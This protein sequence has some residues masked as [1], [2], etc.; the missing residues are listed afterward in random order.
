MLRWLPHLLLGNAE[1]GHEKK[2]GEEE[3]EEEKEKE[4]VEDGV[5]EGEEGEEEEEKKQ[6]E[7]QEPEETGVC[8]LSQVRFWEVGVLKVAQT[9]SRCLGFRRPHRRFALVSAGEDTESEE[10]G[11]QR[12]AGEAQRNGAR[13]LGVETPS[14]GPA[15]HA[16]PASPGSSGNA[17]PLQG[18][19]T[20]PWGETVWPVWPSITRGSPWIP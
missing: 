11:E 6:E 13:A 20:R 3:E 19:V 1:P 5:E 18:H 12:G 14:P 10:A 9:D 4:E 8:P 15:L 16:P 2:R 17:G 7:A